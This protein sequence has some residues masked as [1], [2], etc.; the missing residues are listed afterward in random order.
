MGGAK[1]RFQ[2]APLFPIFLLLISFFWFVLLGT[3]F[4]MVICGY[5]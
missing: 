3:D 1:V 2:Q 4:D 5:G